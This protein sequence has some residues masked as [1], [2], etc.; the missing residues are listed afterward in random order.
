MKDLSFLDKL[1]VLVDVSSSSGL[2]IASIFVIV[3]LAFMM[4]TTN[5]RNSRQT[6]MLYSI[7]YI[8]LIVVMF[9]QYGSSFS[10]MFDYM[11]NN[12]FIAIYF[13]NLAI[14]LAAIIA[15]NIILWKT[16]FNFKEDKLLKVINT[17]IYSIMHYLLIL[18]LNVVNSSKIDVFDNASVYANNDAL[19][20]IGLSS[21]IFM[22]WIIFIIVYKI[23]RGRQ[24]KYEVKPVRKSLPSNIIE[25]AVPKE[26]KEVIKIR[27]EVV[28]TEESVKNRLPSNILEVAVPKEVKEVIKIREEVVPKVVE[29]PSIVNFYQQEQ[30]ELK[31]YENMLTLDDYKTVI[32]LLK[33]SKKESIGNDNT[34][35][36]NSKEVN[37]NYENNYTDTT[38]L[39]TIEDYYE[40]NYEEVVEQPMLDQ[41]L[42]LYKSV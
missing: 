32:E 16:V 19:A 21:T 7:I 29:Q 8:V 15:T 18:I 30:E 41:L 9:I 35:K 33:N 4:I 14:Y 42:N 27:E 31:K 34:V 22:I 24:K 23:I 12:L 38:N 20:L 26:V 17:I 5:K 13:P 37:T 36:V 6:K 25:V 1:K 28:K 40:N 11:M 3:F 39:N 10:T 2:C